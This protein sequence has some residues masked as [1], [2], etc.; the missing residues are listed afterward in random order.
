MLDKNNI[1]RHIAIIM[2]GNGRWAKERGLARSEGHRQGVKRAEEIL[3]AANEIGVKFITFF[4]FSAENWRRPKQ[5]V[6]VLMNLLSIFLSRNLKMM[7]KNNIRLNVIGRR[8]P[9]PEGLWQR[10]SQAKD[11]TK[12]NSGLTA[13]LAFNYGAR[14]EIVDAAK[15]LINEVLADRL[16]LD[17]ISEE[18]FGNFLYTAGIPDPDLLIRTSS[19]LRISNFLLWQLSYSELFFSEVCWPD[20]GR[21]NLEQAIS[22][23]QKRIRR[24]GAI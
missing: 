24:F 20:F 15:R 21:Q 17:K 10:L 22:D 16:S 23:Y 6:N 13:I 2:D 19:E 5:E 8:E 9:I 11:E 1:P 4:A 14:Q 3:K 18:N 12:E 7:M